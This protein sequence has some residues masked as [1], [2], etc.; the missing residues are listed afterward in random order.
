[1]IFRLGKHV[2]TGADI[3]EILDG[4]DLIGTI[5]PMIPGIGGMKGIRVL[6]KFKPHIE[7]TE[8]DPVLLT[9]IRVRWDPNQTATLDSIILGA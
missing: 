8:G 2:M 1:M 7:Q 6:S 3:V 9:D 5:Y 4:E